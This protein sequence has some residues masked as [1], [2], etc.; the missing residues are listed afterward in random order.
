MTT[1]N[2]H[3]ERAWNGSLGRHWAAQHRRFDAM[4]GEADEALFAAAAIVPGERVLDIGC[5]A[6]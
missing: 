5:G 1:V 6:G 2:L 4:L 3:Q